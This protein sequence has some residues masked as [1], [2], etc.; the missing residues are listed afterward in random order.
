MYT[1]NAK[2]LV[3]SR[4]RAQIFPMAKLDLVQHLKLQGPLF[5]SPMAGGPGT[6]ELAAAVCN[7]GGLGALGVPYMKPPDIEKSTVRLR[8]LTKHPFA[9]NL[10]APASEPTITTAA[11]DRALKTTAKYRTELN[12]PTPTFAPPYA[13]N[14]ADQAAMVLKLKPAVLSFTFGRIPTELI[15]EFQK[16][17]T[18]VIGTATTLQEALELQDDGV[19]AVCAQGFEAGGH[20]GIF[21]SKQDDPGIGVFELVHQCATKLQIPVIAAGGIMNAAGIAQA[22]KAGAQVAQLGTAFLC[23]EEAGTSRAYRERLLAPH[24]KTKLTRAFSGRL[25]RGLENRFMQEMDA[26]PEAILEFPAQ[27]SFTR[28]MRNASAKL[29]NGDFLSLW[30]GTNVDLIRQTTAKDLVAEIFADLKK[31]N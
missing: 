11:L 22:L 24:K 15:K 28:D 13:E 12:L 23:C 19:D 31:L 25:A 3:L 10:F 6:P 9:L 7:A 5:L 16:Q 30:A 4:T 17:K 2:F 27:N 21:D 20:R 26:Q 1:F 8:E 18:L 14:F 29:N